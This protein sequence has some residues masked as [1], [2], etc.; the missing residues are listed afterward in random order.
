MTVIDVVS[1]YIEFIWS[2]LVGIVV[3][4][5][6]VVHKQST[7][8]HKR[9]VARIDRIDH[10]LSELDDLVHNTRETFVTTADLDNAVDLII[11]SNEKQERKFEMLISEIQNNKADKSHCTLAH[12]LAAVKSGRRQRDV[13]LV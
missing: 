11:A 13:P 9:I 3:A 6:T 10:D 8:E 12:E 7:A 1:N 5:Y 2:A 4:V